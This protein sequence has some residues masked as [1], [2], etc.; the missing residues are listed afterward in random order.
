MGRMT[1]YGP[2]EISDRLTILALKILV[3]TEAGKDV[4]HFVDERNVLLKEIAARTLNGKWFEQVIGL[5]AINAALWHAEDDLRDLR[6]RYSGRELSPDLN[7][8]GAVQVAFR[9]Q[10]LNDQ[11]A[12]CI[13]QIN[14]D[15]GDH[16]GAEKL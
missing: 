11:R 16:L 5:G 13:E 4:K 15:S 1:N 12:V 7:T 3:G 2:G 9:I 10:T 6:T 8:V 14:K